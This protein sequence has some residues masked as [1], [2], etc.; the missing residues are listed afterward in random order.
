MEASIQWGQAHADLDPTDPVI[1]T[2]PAITRET[3]AKSQHEKKCQTAHYPDRQIHGAIIL[4][5]TAR[6]CVRRH[7]IVFWEGPGFSRGVPAQTDCGFSRRGVLCL[8]HCYT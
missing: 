4:A 8:R 5:S 1:T 2:H 6:L 7:S 3:R